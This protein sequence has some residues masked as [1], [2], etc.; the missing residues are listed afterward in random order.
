M[1]DK[2]YKANE[3]RLAVVGISHD[4]R[5]IQAI[6][7]YLRD[8]EVSFPI[9]L[10]DLAVAMNYV[11]HMRFHVPHFFFV[12]PDGQILE[13]RNPTSQSDLSWF[14]NTEQN[15]ESAI[16]RLLPPEK[17]AGKAQKKGTR[18]PAKKQSASK[19]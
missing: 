19:S 14:A 7:E 11:G 2:L 15:L 3:K 6:R 1:L 18:K 13:E 9:V 8:H 10:G 16:L 17:P 5:G 12:G 4:P